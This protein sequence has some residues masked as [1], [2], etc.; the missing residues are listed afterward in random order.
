M[1]KRIT[2]PWMPAAD[3]GQSLPTFTVNLLVRD[4]G[5]SVKFY[6]TIL[7][8]NTHYHDEDFAA[9]HV[10]TRVHDPCRSHIRKSPVGI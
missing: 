4:V 6:E 7:G 8:G 9:L 3:Y 1:K 2:K 10:A 5:V